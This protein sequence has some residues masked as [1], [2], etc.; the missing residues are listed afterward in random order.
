MLRTP[1]VLLAISLI[2]LGCGAPPA[3]R[4]VNDALMVEPLPKIG[5]DKIWADGFGPSPRD[6]ELDARRAVSEQIVSKVRSRSTAT[7][8]EKNGA[9]DRFTEVRI[10]TDSAF[11]RAELIRTVKVVARGDGF[12]ARAAL[13]KAQV[14]RA[15]RAVFDKGQVSITRIVPVLAEAMATL[16][17]S[18]LLSAEHSPTLLSARLDAIARVM[19]AVG[20]PIR[21]DE[22]AGEQ[23]IS[24]Q[25]TQ[26]RH[27]AV[28]RLRIK[29]NASPAMQRGVVGTLEAA[30]RTRGC[31]FTRAP[32]TAPVEGQPTANATLTLAVRDHQ[33]SGLH[34][35][36]LGLDLAIDD[37]RSKR[38]VLRLTGMPRIAHGGGINRGQ[39]EQ[40]AIKRLAQ[41]LPEKASATLA[42][43]NCR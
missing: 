5:K 31:R 34:W 35:R 11:E 28:I 17:T 23:A 40:A 27:R 41:V 12:V 1:A 18:V 39:A 26:M 21:R 2:S 42:G 20:H 32:H 13:D 15:Y 14:A 16:D 6:A 4:I 33:E 30:L 37:A 19:A 36:Y 9:G 24:S 3:R 43:L 38:S 22:R 10:A 29:G 25:A 8:A 7:E